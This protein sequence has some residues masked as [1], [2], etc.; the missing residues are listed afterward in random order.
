[1]AAIRV[2]G[3]T[4]WRAAPKPASVFHAGRNDAMPYTSGCI[5]RS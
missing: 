2:A 3:G 5:S 1:M 4:A